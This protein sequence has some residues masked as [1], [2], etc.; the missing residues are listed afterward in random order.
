MMG[1]ELAGESH[2][3]QVD[4]RKRALH[5]EPVSTAGCRS[6]G[7][8]LPALRADPLAHDRGLVV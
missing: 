5:R 8:H 2:G 7:Q 4:A 6:V 1:A 3:A